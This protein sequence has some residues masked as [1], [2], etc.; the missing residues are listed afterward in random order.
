M[1]DLSRMDRF[2]TAGQAALAFADAEINR[3][4][5]MIGYINDFWFMMWLCFASIPLVL[6]MQTVRG[7]R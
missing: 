7:R 6:F 4:A 1:F 5:A 2:Q 3:Q